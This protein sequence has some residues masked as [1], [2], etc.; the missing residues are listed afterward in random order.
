[1]QR[2]ILLLLSICALSA[3]EGAP[4]LIS[5]DGAGGTLERTAIDKGIIPDPTQL[6]LE[7]LFEAGPE[8]EN[9]RF[10]AAKKGDDYRVGLFVY[11]GGDQVCEAKGEADLDGET[12]DLTLRS[13]NK[14]KDDVCTLSAV[15][16]GTRIVF[17]GAIPESCNAICAR[18]ASLA[19]VSIPLVENGK[20][21]ASRALG[22]E[23][24]PLCP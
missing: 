5:D 1:M 3:C 15:F 24:E 4:S 16:D 23:L 19:G 8:L 6:D 17:P 7:G 2:N 21:A 9:D 10:C 18:R 11:Y 12:V 20:R 14:N 13:V 22:S